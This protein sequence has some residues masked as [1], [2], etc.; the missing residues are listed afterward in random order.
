[1]N[2]VIF[3]FQNRAVQCTEYTYYMLRIGCLG[4][5][6]SEKAEIGVV[7]FLPS[8]SDDDDDDNDDDCD[9]YD[10]VDNGN[11]DISPEHHHSQK[12]KLSSTF[13][14]RPPGWAPNTRRHW[15]EAGNDH[16]GHGH[17]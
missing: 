17:G 6:D 7:H 15:Q 8:F 4:Y 1:M 14:C 9:D 11:N 3:K 13:C 2:I 5:N 12:P 16:H 10:N